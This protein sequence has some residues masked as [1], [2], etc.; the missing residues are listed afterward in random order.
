ME[1]N[2]TSKL[3][4]EK[5]MFQRYRSA[6]NRL[7]NLKGKVGGRGERVR[8]DQPM[9]LHAYMHNPGDTDDGVVRA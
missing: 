2:E 4:G 9:N 8:R 3:M 7:L 1:S 6:V 5:T